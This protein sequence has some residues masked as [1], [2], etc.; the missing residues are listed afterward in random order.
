MLN[1]FCISGDFIA[2]IGALAVFPCSIIFPL[3]L[4]AIV[5]TSFFT[6]VHS[7]IRC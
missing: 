6:P 7:S 4:T 2:L 3:V 1:P 5:R